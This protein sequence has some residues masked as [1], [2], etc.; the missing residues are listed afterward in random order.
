MKKAEL[1]AELVRQANELDVLRHELHVL[2]TRLEMHERANPGVWRWVP[3]SPSI[4]Q[5]PH[6]PY[7]VTF[8]GT[9]AR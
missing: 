6:P 3:P 5:W 9:D 2:K 4:P 1:E 7:E 8:G